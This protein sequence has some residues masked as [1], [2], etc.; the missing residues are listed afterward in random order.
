MIVFI[1][2]VESHCAIEGARFLG[3]LSNR[4]KRLAPCRCLA[5][6]V[7]E[8]CGNG[9]GVGAYRKFNFFSPPVNVYAKYMTEKVDCDVTNKSTQ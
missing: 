2:F 6:H 3:I 5:G 1:L 8:P 9:D 7:N 4:I